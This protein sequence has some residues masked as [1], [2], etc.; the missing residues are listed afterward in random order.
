MASPTKL[1]P[2]MQEAIIADVA[3]GL[4]AAQIAVK[5]GIHPDSLY[6][7]IRKGL[8]PDAK[9]PW[10]S[11]AM[12]YVAADTAIEQ[13]CL[14]VIRSGA[15]DKKYRKTKRVVRAAKDSTDPEVTT[16]TEWKCGDWRAMAW[17][18][19]R[20]WP[21]RYGTVAPNYVAKNELPL[22]QLL[23]D[24]EGR[25]QSLAELLQNPPAELEEA[26]LQSR[27]A[28]LAILLAPAPKLPE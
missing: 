1:T 25:G 19:E 4:F 14:A 26:I 2:A 15:V 23:A 9:E 11:F 22:Q 17:F 27:E 18:A 20:K 5:N 12:A 28:L 24:A 21:T 7:W 16:E 8:Q 6:D 13:Q 3:T 10:A